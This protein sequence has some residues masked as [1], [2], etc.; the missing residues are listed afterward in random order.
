MLIRFIR[1]EK[2][3]AGYALLLVLI[4]MGISFVILA[5]SMRWTSGSA[6]Q[7][8]RNNQ[9]NTTVSAAEAATEAVIAQMARDFQ[10]Q[11]VNT[12]LDIYAAVTPSTVLPGSWADQYAFS[13]GRGNPNKIYVTNTA[14]PMV[15]NLNSEFAGL[16][17]FVNSFRVIANAAEKDAPYAIAA[18]VNQDF[19]LAAIPIFQFAIFYAIDLEINPGPV[20]AV[21]GK[22]HGNSD[23]YIAPQSGLTFMDSVTSVGK[24]VHDRHPQDPMYGSHKVTPVYNG[25]KP[26]QVG[27]LT[28]PIGT[29]NTPAEVRRIL[30]VPPVDEHPKSL[31]GKQRYYNKCD[32]LVDVSDGGVSV[33]TGLW[34]GFG[35]VPP[36]TTN[37]YSW[38][39]TNASF[40]DHREN[41]WTVTTDIDVLALTSWMASAGASINANC[42]SMTSRKINSVY[43]QDRRVRAGKH[44]VVRVINGRDL[45]PHGLTVA[46][47]QPIYVKGHFNAPS[48]G[49]ADTSAT[50]PASL[51]GDAITVLSEAWADANSNKPFSQRMAAPTTV[52][53]AFLAGIVKTTTSSGVRK[54][55]GGV[56]NFPRFL[57]D[58]TDRTFTYNGSLVVMY[59]SQFATSFWPGTGG[60]PGVYDPPVRKWAFD[61]NFLDYNRLPPETPQVQKLFRGAWNVIAANEVF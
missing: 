40:L 1:R 22:V 7:T 43:V 8:G 25:G 11:G 49:S 52:N 24:T 61:R 2:I 55:S 46:T 36:N 41:K 47:R 35:A 33:K 51:V 21:T 15:T 23:L 34:S 59:E 14:P 4:F 50:R 39:K 18:G 48:P 38:V 53:A 27:A 9:Y 20:M 13:D 6:L 57:E 5:G 54:Y 45:P 42:E 17:G 37:G 31:M 58:W 3:A 16:Y 30:D 60:G 44:T 19:Q 56:E 10:N 12:N 28:L 26:Q 32:L 29:N